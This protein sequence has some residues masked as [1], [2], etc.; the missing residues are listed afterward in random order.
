MAEELPGLMPIAL[1]GPT[2]ARGSGDRIT[3]RH[4]PGR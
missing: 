4:G 2:R 3:D 1:S